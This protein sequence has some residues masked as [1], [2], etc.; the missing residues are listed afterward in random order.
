MPD[1]RLVLRLSGDLYTKAR[2][3][4]LRFLRRLEKNIADAL[5]VHGIPHKLERNWS[6]FYVATEAAAGE[7][8][9]EPAAG[10]LSRVFGLRS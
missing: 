5:T 2:Q 1:R 4:R 8:P 9:A 6:R 3:T 7:E 10:V